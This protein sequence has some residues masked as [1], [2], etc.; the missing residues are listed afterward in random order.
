MNDLGKPG[1][2]FT[3]L[4]LEQQRRFEANLELRKRR[5]TNVSRYLQGVEGLLQE[6]QDRILIVGDRPG[7]SAP[8]DPGFHHTPF[9]STKHCSGW[10]NALQVEAQIPEESLVWINST[11]HRGLPLPVGILDALDPHSIVILGGHARR[12][13]DQAEAWKGYDFV[14]EVPH[15]QYWK[16]FKSKERYP[17]WEVLAGF[18]DFDT[19]EK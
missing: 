2:F 14:E 4:P 1:A 19:G 7:P 8:V 5:Y 16:R 9:Y 11:D 10:L 3:S 15:P 18:V 12:W 17:L 6:S 13:F